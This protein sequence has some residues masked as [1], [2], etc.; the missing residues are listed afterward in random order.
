MKHDWY[1]GK[2]VLITGAASGIG[3][4]LALV[5]AQNG[6]KLALIDLQPGILVEVQAQCSPQTLTFVADIRDPERMSAIISEVL[7]KWGHVDVAIACAG[8]GGINPAPIFS[9]E[10]DAKVM[11][12]NYT[13]T[14]NTLAPLI[15][16]MMARKSGNLVGISS[17]AALRG[18]PFA[19]S[20]SASK[21]AQMTWLESLRID[22]KP[23][24]IY[25]TSIHPGFVATPMA[26]HDEFKMPFKVGPRDSSNRIL[27]AIAAGRSQYHYP[28]LISFLARFNR[29]LPNFIYDFIMPRVS[30]RAPKSAKILSALPSTALTKGK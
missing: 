30:G 23:H 22:L 24:G 4:D 29:L 10:I 3:K 5:L 13:G 7:S 21:A 19:A 14:V 18:L 12:V 1:Q 25:V 26:E 8:V 9:Q 6:A 11:A 28:F 2:N 16:S 17:L 15:P 20:Y 27:R